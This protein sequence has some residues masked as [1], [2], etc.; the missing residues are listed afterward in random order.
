[1]RDW[2]RRIISAVLAAAL[3]NAGIAV[4]MASVTVDGCQKRGDRGATHASMVSQVTGHHTMAMPAADEATA[5]ASCCDLDAVCAD[6][7]HCAPLIAIAAFADPERSVSDPS[8]LQAGSRE[9][10]GHHSPPSL[11]PPILR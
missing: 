11:R 5:S 7:G 4:A 2:V 9:F 1:M 10:R 8:Y 3:L 6:S